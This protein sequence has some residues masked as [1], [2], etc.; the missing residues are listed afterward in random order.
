MKNANPSCSTPNREFLSPMKKK[1]IKSWLED[2]RIINSLD[3]SN[4]IEYFD[5]FPTMEELEY[6][7]WLLKYPKPSWVI[8][9]EKKLKFLEDSL[10]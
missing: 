10:E 7:E 6:H 1:E 3:R 8:F 9:D 5:T 4:E 2:S